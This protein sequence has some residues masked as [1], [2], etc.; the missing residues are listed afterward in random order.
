MII[1]FFSIFLLGLINYIMIHKLLLFAILV[2]STTLF[3]QKHPAFQD[4]A[5]WIPLEKNYNYIATSITPRPGQ[6]P[7]MY[8]TPVKFVTEKE[9]DIF[10]LKLDI[11]FLKYGFTEEGKELVQL[12]G[13]LNLS[14]CKN[15]PVTL[16]FQDKDGNAVQ[17]TST[18]DTGKFKATSPNGKL[19]EFSNY[20]IKFNFD[21]I[22][23]TDIDLNSKDV[24]LKWLNKPSEKELKR[25]RKKARR[26]YEKNKKY[27]DELRN[28]NG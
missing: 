17:F 9:N 12:E 14:C 8:S 19:I 23:A 26:E 10:G 21:R 28:K 5:D 18:D 20:R 7:E 16:E 11:E 13:S 15:K 4:P 1:E 6:L 3:A 27:I 24:V 22:K 25:A 2:G